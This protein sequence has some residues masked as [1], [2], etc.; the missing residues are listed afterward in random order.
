MS[1]ATA[2]GRGALTTTVAAL[3]AIAVLIGLGS[4]QVQRLLWKEDLLARMAAQLSAPP[5]ALPARIERPDD[6]D[7]RPVRVQGRYRHGASLFLAGRVRDGVLGHEVVTPL[8]RDDG[9]ILLVNRGWVSD[10]WRDSAPVTATGAPVT[11]AGVARMPRPPGAFVPDN[12]ATA[13]SWFSMDLT[14]MAAAAGA[15]P[16]QPVYLLA[17]SER[18][19]A[20]EGPLPHRV[21]A[22]LPNNHLGY[23]LTWYGLAATLAVIFMIY[24]RGRRGSDAGAAA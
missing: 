2:R 5:E 4:W 13:N 3:A 14:A 7:F 17:G 9:G 10:A 21:T 1:D 16:V 6:W 19:A 18:P 22:D 8:I 24:M 11:V 23:A 20:A 12:N 15:G